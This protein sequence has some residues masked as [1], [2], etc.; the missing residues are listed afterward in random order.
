VLEKVRLLLA[1]ASVMLSITSCGGIAC[2]ALN[3]ACM[4]RQRNSALRAEHDLLLDQSAIV[5]ASIAAIS[6][7]CA[8]HALAG[9]RTAP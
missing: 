4:Q 2:L 1:N 9:G 8:T 5:L 3:S 6:G 7:W